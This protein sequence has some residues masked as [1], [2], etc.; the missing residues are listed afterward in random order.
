MEAATAA[1]AT[2]AAC[3]PPHPIVPIAPH[4]A[5]LLPADE[6]PLPPRP[7]PHTAG[8]M[9][10]PAAVYAP[11]AQAQPHAAPAPPPPADRPTEPSAKLL[12]ALGPVAALSNAHSGAMPPRFY[13]PQLPPYDPAPVQYVA[14]APIEDDEHDGEE[15]EDDLLDMMPGDDGEEGEGDGE[16]GAED[17]LGLVKTD[18]RK[19]CPDCAT[20][21]PTTQQVCCAF[22][23]HAPSACVSAADAAAARTSNPP[24]SGQRAASS[25][26]LGTHPAR[27]PPFRADLLAMQPPLPD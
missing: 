4:E 11:R 3:L 22:H 8:G 1:V 26:R 13:E 21:N 7:P 18:P 19:R 24:P 2:A 9:P 6:G 23:E 15:D 5:L 12:G 27:T 17:L 25:T 14:G 10:L 16:D 20:S